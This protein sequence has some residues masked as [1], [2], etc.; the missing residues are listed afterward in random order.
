MTTS[1]FDVNEQILSILLRDRKVSLDLTIMPCIET[2]RDCLERRAD[3][4]V[5]DWIHSVARLSYQPHADSNTS[6]D[7]FLR[8]M[9]AQERRVT[10]MQ[11]EF[12]FS[13]DPVELE[14]IKRLLRPTRCRMLL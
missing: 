13:M 5:T 3:I 9:K 14:Q 10:P 4:L 6:A 1:R 7:L 8:L 2:E 11:I 12:L